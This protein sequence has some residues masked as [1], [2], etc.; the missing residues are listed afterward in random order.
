MSIVE[1][2]GQL[3]VVG[4]KVVDKNG[5]PVQLSGMSLFWSQWQPQFWTKETVAWLKQTWGI[6]LLRCPM[7]VEAGGYLTP[8]NKQA[9]LKKLETVVDAALELGIY[10]VIDWHDHNADQHQKEAAGFFKKMAKKYGSYPNVIFEVFNEPIKQSWEEVIKPYHEMIVE[11]IREHSTNL[12]VLGT[13][14]WSQDVD[15]AAADPVAGENLAYTIHFYANTHKQELRDKVSKALELGAAVFATEWGTCDASGDGTVNL[16]EAQ[17]W[18]DFFAEHHI[19]HANWAVSDKQEACSALLPGASGQG[20]WEDC[21]LTE[22]GHFVRSMLRKEEEELPLPE[23]CPRLTTPPP[24]M[25]VDATEDCSEKKCCNEIGHK[26]FQ[27]NEYWAAC[28]S[29]CTPGIDPMDPPE[30][31]APWTCKELTREALEAWPEHFHAELGSSMWI[32][33]SF[34]GAAYRPRLREDPL[35]SHCEAAGLELAVRAWWRGV[36]GRGAT[37]R[38]DAWLKKNVAGGVRGGAPA[39]LLRCGIPERVLQ[40]GVQLGQVLANDEGVTKN[41]GGVMADWQEKVHKKSG[42]SAKAPSVRHF[43]DKLIEAPG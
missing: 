9:E 38:E 2:H 18:L 5:E 42:A 17:A 31:A 28:K 1:K 16:A 26:C 6:T 10:V 34:D 33:G 8:G 4:N 29:S 13:R 24:G 25:C 11:V 40:S 7:A 36:P 14:I 30:W 3:Q 39:R 19:S 41:W 27:K 23:P 37:R 22:S 43:Q 32:A 20:G 15:V 21:E 35:V 12:I